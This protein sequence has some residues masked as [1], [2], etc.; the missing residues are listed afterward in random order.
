MMIEK[1]YKV[2]LHCS[3]LNVN[4]YDCT[5]EFCNKNYAL[6]FLVLYM[7]LVN[8][9]SNNLPTMTHFALKTTMIF[10]ETYNIL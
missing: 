8:R 10:T 9:S 4:C 6:E 7:F 2:V 5:V 3:K 1:R